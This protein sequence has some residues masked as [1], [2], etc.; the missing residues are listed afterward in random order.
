MLRGRVSGAEVS[1]MNR[2]PGISLAEVLIAMFVLALGLLGVL[3]L[4][5]LGAVRMAQAIKDDLCQVHNLNMAANL[6]WVWREETVRQD[7]SYRQLYPVQASPNLT[8]SQPV[9]VGLYD[10]N[11]Y[12]DNI[13]P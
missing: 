10:F 11:N 9:Y 6:H 5:P 1:V 7:G 4:F 8:P 12:G 13:D 3:S 2:R